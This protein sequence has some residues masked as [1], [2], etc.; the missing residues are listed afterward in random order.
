M[1]VKIFGRNDASPLP[2]LIPHTNFT[3]SAGEEQVRLLK[4]ITTY[5]EILI[6]ANL[7]NSQDI[8]ELVMVLAAIRDSGSDNLINLFLPYLPYSRQD[9]VCY[10]GEAFGLKAFARLVYFAA[11]NN[12]R[13]TTW[14]AHSS[15]ANQVFHQLSVPFTSVNVNYFIRQFKEAGQLTGYDQI[16][17][18]FVIVA[19]DQGAV[20]RASLAAKTLNVPADRVLFG[21]KIRDPGN[22]E[23]L[24]LMI[25]KKMPD[26][27]E[28]NAPEN[29]DIKG[30][31]VLIVDDICD[32]GRTFI[33]LAKALKSYGAG[34]IDLYV[35]HGIFS[36]GFDVFYD[37]TG[38][39]LI[40]RFLVP[41]I[42]PN[43]VAPDKAFSE[44]ITL[45]TE[46]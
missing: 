7:A 26:G 4:D 39:S 29:L 22:G 33:E 15:Q 41:N 14:D 45:P 40:D 3:F 25:L 21:K 42:F 44:L 31:R 10:P 5:P 36:K 30:K 27:T 20:S 46:Q 11:K 24:G 32:G 38:K 37:N 34:P 28:S 16:E 9:R 8:I 2:E 23:I 12:L 18:D 19:P 43:V 1:T 17:N 13:V 6:L 35:T